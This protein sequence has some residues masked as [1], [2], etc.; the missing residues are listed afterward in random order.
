MQALIEKLLR[1]E[2][3]TF[4]NITNNTLYCYRAFESYLN[5]IESALGFFNTSIIDNDSLPKESEVDHRL[6]DPILHKLFVDVVPNDTPLSLLPPS[7]CTPLLASITHKSLTKTHIVIQTHG[8][9]FPEAYW[10]PAALISPGSTLVL[11][12]DTTTLNIISKRYQ[13][14]GGKVVRHPFT[15]NK[16]CNAPGTLLVALGYVCREEGVSWARPTRVVLYNNKLVSCWGDSQSSWIIPD[17]TCPITWL[18]CSP[19]PLEHAL[20]LEEGGRRAREGAVYAITPP[21]HRLYPPDAVRTVR[22]HPGVE[23]D[24][25]MISVLRKAVEGGRHVGVVAFSKDSKAGH[26][27]K[28]IDK[29]GIPCDNKQTASLHTADVFSTTDVPV[30]I[31]TEFMLLSAWPRYCSSRQWPTLILHPE[32]I[33][34]APSLLKE[35]GHLLWPCVAW[36]VGCPLPDYTPPP[37]VV[38]YSVAITKRLSRFSMYKHF[39]SIRSIHREPWRPPGS[40]HE[41]LRPA[42][43]EATLA[44]RALGLELALRSSRGVMGW[45]RTQNNMC[46]AALLAGLDLGEGC[47]DVGGTL[48]CFDFTKEVKE[49]VGLVDCI[50]RDS[51]RVDVDRHITQSSSH[52]QGPSSK[53]LL[54]IVR[55]AQLATGST[56]REMGQLFPGNN[57]GKCYLTLPAKGAELLVS[58]MI[59]RGILQYDSNAAYRSFM[60]RAVRTSDISRISLNVYLQPGPQFTCWSRPLPGMPSPPPMLLPLTDAEVARYMHPKTR[61]ATVHRGAWGYPQSLR[62]SR[63]CTGV[64]P[65]AMTARIDALQESMLRAGMQVPQEPSVTLFNPNAVQRRWDVIQRRLEPPKEDSAAGSAVIHVDIPVVDVSDSESEREDPALAR[66]DLSPAVAIK[67]WGEQ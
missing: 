14:A 48:Q 1:T 63:E 27:H 10:M 35:L 46:G 20:L 25:A 42:V 3:E 19:H 45:L 32:G 53:P 65:E 6:L 38:F 64:E 11:A 59:E 50:F 66:G 23:A 22:T 34:S 16:Y 24:K 30:L 41:L 57:T 54:T 21:F 55:L 51:Q 17:L 18:T 37:V 9:R 4:G 8:H 13:R 2:I 7:R 40:S 67:S 49:L 26:I 29:E 44:R 28:L 47:P 36:P 60:T 12:Q 31:C 56:S 5:R 61:Q 58:L 15:R 52:M 62:L 33:T 43:L 39:V